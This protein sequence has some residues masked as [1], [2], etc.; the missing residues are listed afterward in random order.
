MMNLIRDIDFVGH[1]FG[2]NF[3]KHFDVYKTYT[4]GLVSLII[5]ILTLTITIIQINVMVLRQ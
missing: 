3:N 1:K 5:C 4:G 2:L